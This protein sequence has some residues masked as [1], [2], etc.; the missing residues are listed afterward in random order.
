MGIS[1]NPTNLYHS[2]KTPLR[3]S[4]TSERFGST[5]WRRLP[6]AALVIQIVEQVVLEIAVRIEHPRPGLDRL[7]PEDLGRLTVEKHPGQGKRHGPAGAPADGRHSFGKE[8]EVRGHQTEQKPAV[9][10][11]LTKPRGGKGEQERPD[12]QKEPPRPPPPE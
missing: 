7:V 11:I 3:L 9:K 5:A 10:R 1:H 4:S 2:A 6:S 12:D 8:Q